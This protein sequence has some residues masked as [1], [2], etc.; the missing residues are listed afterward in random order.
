MA[1]DGRRFSVT[2]T[3]HSRADAA[4]LFRL[5]ADGGRWSEWAGPFVPRSSWERQGDPSPGGIGAIRRLGR[6]PVVVREETVAY[7][8]DRRHGYALRT[9]APVRGYRAE[10]TFEPRDGGGTDVVWRGTFTELI[11][12]TGPLAARVFQLLLRSL[13]RRLVGAAEHRESLRPPES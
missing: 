6:W 3:A 4:T 12:G 8:Q 13:T 5:V 9:P 7:E 1:R 10:V 2:A 11:P